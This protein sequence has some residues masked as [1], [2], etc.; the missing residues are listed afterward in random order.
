MIRIID[1]R[2]QGSRLSWM[3]DLFEQVPTLDMPRA[4]P[5]AVL[6]PE[7]TESDFGDL[8]DADALGLIEAIRRARA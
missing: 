5:E 1:P 3:S 4:T 2:Q 6:L 7:V 8:D